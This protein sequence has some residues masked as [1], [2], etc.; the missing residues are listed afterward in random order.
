MSSL[1]WLVLLQ[2]LVAWLLETRLGDRTRFDVCVE[3]ESVILIFLASFFFSRYR[4]NA[5]FGEEKLFAE[6]A[7]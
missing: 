7:R 4:S 5:F 2:Y 3:C 1:T 6:D